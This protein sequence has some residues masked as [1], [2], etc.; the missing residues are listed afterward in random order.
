MTIKA[1]V[2]KICDVANASFEM[3]VSVTEDRAV[4]GCRISDECRKGSF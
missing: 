3:L 2:E 1:L 4:E